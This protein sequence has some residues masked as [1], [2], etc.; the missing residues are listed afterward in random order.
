MRSSFVSRYII[1]GGRITQPAL[2]NIDIGNVLNK[3]TNKEY[4]ILAYSDLIKY[5]NREL[6]FY[7]IIL[8]GYG[9]NIGHWTLLKVDHKNRTVYFFD[10]YGKPPDAQWPFLENPF[11]QAEPYHM[12]SEIINDLV[13]KGYVFTYNTYNIQGT[14][15]SSI[16]DS[17]CGELVIMRIIYNKISDKDFYL[18]M[19]KMGGYSIYDIIKSYDDK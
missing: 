12:L 11:N 2:S 14:L 15:K 18:T 3:V 4:D 8:F 10:P 19:L 16:A 1:R 13:K 5:R 6:P 17:E 9:R 7:T